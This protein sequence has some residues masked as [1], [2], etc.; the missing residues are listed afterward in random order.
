MRKL[1]D[2]EHDAIQ[3]K[4]LE[5]GVVVEALSAWAAKVLDVIARLPAKTLTLY[6]IRPP[7]EDF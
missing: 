6:M 2:S 3:C 4:E 5:G 7:V 1:K